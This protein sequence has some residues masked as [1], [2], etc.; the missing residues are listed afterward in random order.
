MNKL[1]LILKN[2]KNKIEADFDLLF[3]RLKNTSKG[4]IS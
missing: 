3:A 4:T 1:Y 2:L